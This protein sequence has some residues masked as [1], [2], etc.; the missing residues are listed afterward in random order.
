MFIT[1]ELEIEEI[2]TMFLAFVS[3][4]NESKILDANYDDGERERVIKAASLIEKFPIW[5]EHL[6]NHNIQQVENIATKH[7]LKNDVSYIFFD[8]VH[9]TLKILEEISKA[10]RGVR[11]REDNVLLMFVSRLKKLANELGVFI[12]TATQVNGNW[13]KVDQAT[14]NLLR[15]AKSMADL[16]EFLIA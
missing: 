13:D 6:S 4:V 12:F 9:T 16:N 3:G 8:Y 11:L 5:I 15:G 7:K 10:S 14:Q 1:T 2:Q